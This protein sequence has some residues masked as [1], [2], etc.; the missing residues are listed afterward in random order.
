MI[1]LKVV[2]AYANSEEV[3]P[4]TTASDALI[5]GETCINLNLISEDDFDYTTL[6]HISPTPSPISSL[7]HTWLP[8]NEPTNVQNQLVEYSVAEPR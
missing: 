3:I 6:N 8:I 1:G 2:E 5:Y 4:E 7:K